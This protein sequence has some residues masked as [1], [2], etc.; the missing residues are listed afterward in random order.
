MKQFTYTESKNNLDRF[1]NEDKLIFKHQCPDWVTKYLPEGKMMCDLFGEDKVREMIKS[2]G[3]EYKSIFEVV[4]VENGNGV[5]DRWILLESEIAKSK[6]RYA[7][8]GKNRKF[9]PSVYMD[10]YAIPTPYGSAELGRLLNALFF[11]LDKRL[12]GEIFSKEVDGE[13]SLTNIKVNE[14]IKSHN[15]G[16]MTL[17]EAYDKLRWKKEAIKRKTSKIKLYCSSPYLIFVET[18]RGTIHLPLEGL[19]KGNKRDCDNTMLKYL[20]QYAY[21][22]HEDKLE[23][24]EEL[25][26]TPEYKVMESVFFDKD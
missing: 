2:I 9:Y 22:D 17:S 4:F 20:Y 19:I 12:V 6:E 10:A 24:M 13:I 18:D 8:V 14:L 21:K 5:C 25:K 1:I 15:I 26:D 3:L 23:W 7:G 11:S 16:D